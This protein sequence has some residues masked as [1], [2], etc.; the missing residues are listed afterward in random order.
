VVRTE[1]YPVVRGAAARRLGAV[2]AVLAGAGWLAVR[3]IPRVEVVGDSMRPTLQ[4]GD[5]LVLWPGGRRARLRPG[6]LVAFPDPRQASRVMVKRV[7]SVAPGQV[8][9]TGDNPA[10][11]TD[12]RHFGPVT[13]DRLRGRAVYRYY[14]ADRRGRLA[15]VRPAARDGRAAGGTVGL[16]LEAELDRVLAIDFLGDLSSLSVDE[17]RA[18][19]DECTAVGEKIS[20]LRR[21]VHVRIDI[22]LA[23]LR[24]RAE[25]GDPADVAGLVDDLSGVLAAN[26]YSPEHQRMVDPSPPPDLDQVTAEFEASLGPKG[27]ADLPDLG[28]DE[29]RTLADRLTALDQELSSRRREVFDRVDAL[30]AELTRRYSS[31][32]ATVDSVLR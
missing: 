3:L 4:P 7:E 19:R 14:P 30:G 27:L 15:A 5:R 32:E 17:L 1:H 8:R 16:V 11:S 21:L 31:G 13:V 22:V 18:R 24:R 23:E 28:D 29:I 2:F 12:S 10:A 26:V 20:Y 25:G 9:V 6:D